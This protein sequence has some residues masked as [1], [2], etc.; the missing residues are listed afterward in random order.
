MGFVACGRAATRFGRI[1]L[2]RRDDPPTFLALPAGFIT[3]KLL[4]E[5]LEH[6]RAFGE[7]HPRGWT[8]VVV[9]DA[10]RAVHPLNPIWLRRIPELPHLAR[11]VAVASSPR[12]RSVLRALRRLTGID[13]VVAELAQA[14]GPP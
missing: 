6:A 3:P 7:Q 13:D 11:Y 4:R 9:L 2:A 8:Y 14:V 1:D 12:L 5:D 10:V